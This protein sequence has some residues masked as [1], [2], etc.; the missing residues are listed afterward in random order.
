MR[1]KSNMED[2][3]KGHF[4]HGKRGNKNPKLRHT[5]IA[6]LKPKRGQKTGPKTVS[7]R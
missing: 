3:E 7:P 2:L 5:I 4:E 6:F 1:K